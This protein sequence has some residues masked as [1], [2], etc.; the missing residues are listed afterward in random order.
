MWKITLS[1]TMEDEITDE[2]GQPR[3]F[4]I[5]ESIPAGITDVDQWE[6]VV[7]EVGFR[8]MRQLFTNGL[9]IWDAQVVASYGLGD[10]SCQWVKRGKLGLEIRTLFGKVQ[11]KRQR[12][13]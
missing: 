6:Q 1:A 7:R 3:T 5:V 11:I 8:M 9:E 12:L 4:N 2:M 13:T 10:T